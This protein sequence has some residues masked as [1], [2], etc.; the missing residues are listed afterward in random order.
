[1]IRPALSTTNNR[2]VSPGGVAIATG[3]SKTKP[4]NA[5]TTPNPVMGV[6]C[7][8]CSEVA[9]TRPGPGPDQD[10]NGASRDPMLN[11][12]QSASGMTKR[13]VR[14]LLRHGKQTVRCMDS[15]RTPPRLL[16]KAS[17]MSCNLLVLFGFALAGPILNA[18][19][20]TPQL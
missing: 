9:A 8:S 20:D 3:S 15:A 16:A 5:S 17:S 4:G 2:F 10:G 19:K 11:Q 18:L 7:G 1:M 6:S 14:L 13:S 12:P